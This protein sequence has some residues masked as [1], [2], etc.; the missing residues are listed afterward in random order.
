MN[1]TELQRS[2]RQLRL[3]RMANVLESRLHQAQAE[4]MAP[5]DLL[6]A[7]VSDELASRF[8]RLLERRRKRAGFRD[9]NKTLDAFDFTFN[10][11]MNRSL[12]FDLASAAFIDRREGRAVSRPRGAQAKATWRRPSVTPP[13]CKVTRFSI[14]RLMSFCKSWPMLL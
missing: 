13:S 10:P 14:A 4:P 12:I 6:S 9:A 5:I 2:R 3:G 8:D 1:L 7:L 11:K